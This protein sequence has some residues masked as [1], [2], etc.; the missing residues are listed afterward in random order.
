MKLNVYE[1][2]EWN[3]EYECFIQISFHS[4]WHSNLENNVMKLSIET[5]LIASAQKPQLVLAKHLLEW[6]V[7]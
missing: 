7:V 2:I 3:W 5:D 6:H 4:M 1:T